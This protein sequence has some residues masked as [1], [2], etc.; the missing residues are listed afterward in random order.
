MASAD[1]F[2]LVGEVFFFATLVVLP[3][4]NLLIKT[5]MR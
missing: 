4:V 3:L 1:L 5:R 2:L